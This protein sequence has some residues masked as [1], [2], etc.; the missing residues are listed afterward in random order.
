M[1]H[2]PPPDHCGL[3]YAAPAG[4]IIP[5][6]AADSRAELSLNRWGYADT[7]FS[8]DADSV[9]RLGG[10]RYSLCGLAIDRLFP[11]ARTQL[12]VPLD[13]LDRHEF[14]SPQ[15]QPASRLAPQQLDALHAALGNDGVSVDPL[16]RRRHGH[17]H[18][19]EDIWAANYGQLSR[20]PDA[21]VYPRDEAAVRE[22]LQLA[23]TLQLGLIPYGGGTNVTAACRC[24]PDEARPIIS[25]DMA[26]MNRV[27]WIDA[28]NRIACIEAGATGA[29]INAVL[30]QHGF[31][32]GHEPDSYELSTLG[33]WI[34]TH[35][36]GMKKNRYGNIEDIVLDCRVL[37]PTGDL[38]R[39]NSADRESVG[40]DHRRLV[41]GS[42]GRFGIITQALVRIHR[43]PQQQR[44]ESLIF[45]D[46][47][48]GVAF[49]HAL[50]QSG[51]LPASIRLM[52]NRQFILGQC[53]KPSPRGFAA[54]KS[55]LQKRWLRQVK[56]FDLDRMAACTVLFEG[57]R[58]EVQEQYRRV[59]HLLKRHGGLFGGAGNGRQGYTLTF[60][61][62]YLRDFLLTQWIIAESFETTVPWS[63]VLQLCEA[64]RQRVYA[65]HAALNL[66]GRPFLSWRLTQA[67]HGSACLYFYLGF[68][69]KGVPEPSQA[70][71]HIEHAARE[72][73]LA[74]GGTLSHHHGIGKLR[75]DFLPAIM[76][77]PALALSQALKQAIDP[78]KVLVCGNQ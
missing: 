58:A 28:H 59:A 21:V 49:F 4:A 77:A 60:G 14:K 40:F 37:T 25:V 41:L 27:R 66:P 51:T 38:L 23:H 30:A 68:Y 6:P 1:T 29:Q 69:Y 44:H 35:A 13:P 72:A 10:A 50:Q 34:A 39:S 5:A 16:V 20:I 71:S 78:D 57:T 32:L 31:T 12:G 36:S 19:Q 2:A 76:S 3:S 18:S 52:D 54:I 33:G 8:V 74:S 63:G 61:I 43:L 56:G 45:P 47:A 9:V 75:R 62:A 7:R 67:Y 70:Y 24:P 22:V 55:A 17:G 26:H 65:E 15:Q 11:W 53:L 48:H 64:V 46:F 73:I 42:E